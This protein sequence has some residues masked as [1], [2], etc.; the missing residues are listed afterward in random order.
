VSDGSRGSGRPE[1]TVDELQGADGL[2]EG[3]LDLGAELSAGSPPRAAAPAVPKDYIPGLVENFRRD[4]VS[5]FVI[6]LIALP[7]CL[8]IA[9]ASGAPPI[10]G[11]ITGIVG[12]TLVALVSGSYVTI[13]GPAA[14]LIVVILGAIEG[15][16]GFRYAL[17]VGLVAGAIQIVLGLLRSG[18]LTAFFPLSV[19]HGMLAG[20]GI[21][22]MTGQIHIALGVENPREHGF[23]IFTVI[24]ESFAELEPL[25]AAIGLAA[26]LVMVLWPKVP[27]A[28]LRLVP[29]PLVAVVM[30][31]VGAAL[32]SLDEE[33]LVPLPDS[34]TEGFAAPDFS[35]ILTGT[36]LYYIFLFV[37][38]AS[39]ES[40]LTAE[41]VDKLDP[42]KRRSDMNRELVG[43]GAGNMVVSAIGGIP[44]IAEVVRSSANIF[45]GART[46]WSN[47]FHGLFLLAFV[48]L[49][50]GLLQR[51]PTAAL[52]GILLVVGFKLAHPKEFL[53][54]LKI[55]RLELVL[56]AVTAATVVLTDLLIGVGAGIVVGLVVALAR[57]TSVGN[58]FRPRM[59][60]QEG[61]TITATFRG[62]LGFTNFVG[63]RSKLDALPRGRH[64]VLDFSE[65][66]SIDHT[67]VERL[68]DFEE[69]YERSGGHV[70]RHGT[71]RLKAETD[72]PL[73]AVRAAPAPAG[74]VG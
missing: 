8:G 67:V 45:N 42:Y 26:V 14:G 47:F 11:V 71:E 55:G 36:S 61:E 48:A 70:E 7:L 52:A 35:R 15:L 41:A 54:T 64:V 33:L 57:G 65:V 17:A 16:G 40:L 63:V 23:H 73:A 18:K 21:I 72:H 5:G 49:L 44:M 3:S 27:V 50:P 69:D 32:F 68:H 59:Q 39:L 6:F 58:L 51:I 43:K 9:A 66:Q 2:P 4:V 31:I 29:A 46:R 12:G 30:G 24:P 62:A 22:I 56:M 1:Q 25:A 38:V 19:V 28:A 53:G 13:N 20:I 34:I 10:A 74:A 60:V 37:F